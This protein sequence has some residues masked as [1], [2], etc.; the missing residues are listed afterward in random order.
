[1]I[2]AGNLDETKEDTIAFYEFKDGKFVLLKS[3]PYG[4]KKS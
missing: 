2:F 4:R 1:M 3:M